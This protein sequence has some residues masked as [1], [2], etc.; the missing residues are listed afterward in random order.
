MSATYTKLKSG[1]WGLRIVGPAPS[2][3]A[4]ILVQKK[5]G[6]TKM[7]KIGK[8]VWEGDNVALATVAALNYR[9]SDLQYS[10][11][12]LCRGCGGYVRHAPHHR[13][14]NGFCGHCAFDEYDA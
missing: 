11:N 3:G 8:V 1:E 14:M 4:E 10:G 13:A 5:D 9:P 7:E 6:S 2:A 12:R